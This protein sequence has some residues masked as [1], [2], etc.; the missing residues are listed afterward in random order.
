MLEK[1]EVYVTATLASNP[2]EPAHPVW[3]RHNEGNWF[4]CDISLTDFLWGN[5]DFVAIDGVG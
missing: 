4:S 5:P 3:D 2:S 1:Q